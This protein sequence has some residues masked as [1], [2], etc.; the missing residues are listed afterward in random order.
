[1]SGPWKIRGA[2]RGFELTAGI[3]AAVAIGLLW[4]GAILGWHAFDPRDKR[5]VLAVVQVVM[6][7][8]GT[9]M[10]LHDFAGLVRAPRG[11][12]VGTLSHFIVMP[13]TGFA[14]ARAF[15][16]P[17]EVA[18]GIVLI[19]SCSSGLAS[20]VMAYL[21][22][23]NLALSVTITAMTT[24]MAP[25]ATPLLMKLFAGSWV[26]VAFLPM[27]TEIIR[28]V[29]VPIGAAMYYDFLKG[30]D[31][32]GR[33]RAVSLALGLTA[34]LIALAATGSPSWGGRLIP[35]V[36]TFVEWVTLGAEAQ[37]AGTVY[38]LLSRRFHRIDRLMP[39]ASILGIIYF[40]LVTTAAGR[41][42]LLRI[43]GLLFVAAVLHNAIGYALGYGISRGC[44]LDRNSAR[45][46]AFEVGILNGGMAT[47]LAGAMGKLATVGLASAVFSPWMNLSGSLLANYWRRRPVGPTDH[48]PGSSPP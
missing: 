24:L 32:A 2:L 16:F 46:V 25:V 34:G 23:A 8:M 48:P 33:R 36:S 42:D 17:A 12:I 5:V 45:A 44:G 6:F 19:G 4:P 30:V 15:H 11:V 38:F 18:A 39:I 13:L 40:T 21:A 3:V 10:S 31:P 9:Q 29:V 26:T 1:M 47:G 20:N 43:G 27:V 28:I 37:V 35:P 22:R 7:G 41:D 14:L